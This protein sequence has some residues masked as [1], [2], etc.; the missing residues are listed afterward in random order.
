M[1]RARLRDLGITI[2]TLP[3]GPHNAITDV[4]GVW[5]GQ[6]TLIY[7]EPRVAR[8]GVTMI[9]PREGNIWT[10]NAFA[11]YH[12]FNGTGEMTGVHWLAESGLLCYP[13]AI[14][15]SHQV[16]IVRDSLVAYTKENNLSDSSALPVVAETYDGWLND[17]DAFH[18]TQAHIYAAL[19]AARSGPVEEGNVGGGTG[20]ICHDFKGGIGTASRLVDC[21]SGRY[22]VGALVQAN[23][24]DRA[25]LREA[26]LISHDLERHAEH[27]AVFLSPDGFISIMVNEED[28][29]R[30]HA[31]T[32][33]Y[34]VR[35]AH[36]RI[37][38][39]DD[40]LSHRLTFAFSPRLGFL[41]AC[42]TNT[43][44]GLRASV[45]LHLPGLVLAGK[46]ERIVK[47]ISGHGFAVRGFYGEG[48]NCAGDLYQISNEV[49]LGKSEG[50]ILTGLLAVI[51]QIIDRERRARHGLFEKRTTFV[52]DS[53]WRS[54]ATLSQ[55]RM[56]NSSEAIS[57]L[58]RLRLGIDR[59]HFNQ[60]LTH[61]DLNRLLI[62]IQPAHLMADID[63]SADSE[64]RDAARAAFLRSRLGDIVS[65]N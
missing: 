39:V 3:P 47:E 4:P 53:I 60:R 59:G 8:T 5:V 46:I 34:R 13:I 63:P 65:S 11:A 10:D 56:I 62:E 33:G 37:D 20:M 2:G 57:L 35:E 45:M 6:T 22:T 55:A 48:T 18:L 16:G 25:L 54:Y 28:H 42:P 30:M 61:Q 12:T 27:C 40:V 50:D 24:G 29:L 38:D 31:I 51:D 32:S 49:T 64:A 52:E 36:R 26:H 15:N 23:Y 43:G 9:V 58:S 19:H 1:A 7:D 41:T 44:T 17:I 14:T 21:P